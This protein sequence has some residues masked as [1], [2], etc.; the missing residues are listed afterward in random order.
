MWGEI[1][2]TAAD[3]QKQLARYKAQ[4]TPAALKSADPR[5]GRTVFSKTCQ[6]CHKL[7]GQGG[8]IGPDLT[9]SN[10]STSTTCSRT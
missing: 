8:T 5:N 1:R 10:R 3:K 6:H 7:Y 2:E 4:L 9:G